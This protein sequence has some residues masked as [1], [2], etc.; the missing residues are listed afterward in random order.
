[1][2]T[3]LKKAKRAP[4]FTTNTGVAPQTTTP[5]LKVHPML[6]Q[7]AFMSTPNGYDPNRAGA[8]GVPPPGKA[9]PLDPLQQYQQQLLNQPARQQVGREAFL[10]RRDTIHSGER[11]EFRAFHG[12]E[13]RKKNENWLWYLVAMG[14]FSLG[15][16]FVAVPMYQVFCQMTGTGGTVQRDRQIDELNRYMKRTHDLGDVTLRPIEV[17]FETTVDPNLDWEFYP[18]QRDITLRIGETAL[19]FFKAKNNSKKPIIGVSTYNV[20]P[21]QAGIYFNKIQCFCFD[22][23][24]LRA[25]E[26]IDMPVFFFLDPAMADDWRMDNVDQVQLC[27]TFFQVE[28]DE[29]ENDDLVRQA[30]EQQQQIMM[31]KNALV[32]FESDKTLSTLYQQQKNANNSDDVAVPEGMEMICPVIPPTADHNPSGMSLYKAMEQMQQQNFDLPPQKQQEQQQ[33]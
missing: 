2:S 24:R 10:D 3:T 19:A 9:K 31:A 28:E 33:Q 11:G 1:M 32:H 22:E 30:Q 13:L 27:Y 5:H 14:F 21:P 25:G 6:R 23:Q 12:E 15:M 7:R 8:Q 26:E 20:L 16:S 18:C 29:E 4:T 17:I